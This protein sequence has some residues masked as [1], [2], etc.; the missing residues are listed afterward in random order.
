MS[1]GMMLPDRV[2]LEKFL[3]GAIIFG[4]AKERMLDVMQVIPKEREY[5]FTNN[6]NRCI[7]RILCQLSNLDKLPNDATLIT[8][9]IWGTIASHR[10]NYNC[11]M[12]SLDEFSRYIY[13]MS[14]DKLD[15]MMMDAYLDY[16]NIVKWEYDKNEY[17]KIGTAIANKARNVPF[18][19]RDN[20]VSQAE[21][22]INNLSLAVRNSTGLCD[23]KETGSS[24]LSKIK[25]MMNWEPMESGLKT[26]F[27]GLDQLTGGF[28][29]GE[30]IIV[31]GKTGAGKSVLSSNIALNVACNRDNPR[32]VLL[33]SMEMMP[34]QLTERI[35]AGLSRVNIKQMNVEYERVTNGFY[36]NTYG[37]TLGKKIESDMKQK[38][39]VQLE[40]LEIASK[41]NDN[42][43]IFTTTTGNLNAN[44]I[45]SLVL[46]KTREIENDSR[47]PK[48]GLIV[49][50]YLQIMEPVEKG[51]ANRTE[52]VGDMSR[53]LKR[54]AKETGIPVLCLAQLSRANLDGEQ[55]TLAHLRESGSI[56]QDADKVVFIWSPA[57]GK[58]E[59]DYEVPDTEDSDVAKRLLMYKDQ[60]HLKLTVA[61]NRS[62][63]Q[64]TVDIIGD[65]SFQTFISQSDAYKNGGET[66]ESF[67]EKYYYKTRSGEDI[68]WPLPKDNLP[69]PEMQPYRTLD[70][71]E[72]LYVNHEN[73]IVK[74]SNL[75]PTTKP[76]LKQVSITPTSMNAETI[77][78]EA[79][80]PPPT[81]IEPPT[82]QTPQ[83]Q[84]TN[85]NLDTPNQNT[86]DEDLDY[87]SI[88]FEPT[89]NNDKI[90]NDQNNEAT[91]NLEN[92]LSQLNNL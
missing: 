77:T 37:E 75:I 84:S 72:M 10:K 82:Y 89:N 59:A 30:L 87:M 9:E 29:P 43:P 26:G 79:I 32:S 36:R 58:T 41:Y 50:D 34:E 22:K 62:G 63:E 56:E 81:K 53:R 28:N 16:A 39:L 19:E 8:K 65:F 46:Q 90:I 61:K 78:N 68:F 80:I 67:F 21:S 64:G 52:E 45:K 47:Y 38:I 14:V 17:V 83:T 15:G 25:K 7:Y 85:N 51:A 11:S 12:N 49:I 18:S 35:L 91:E 74:P 92:L 23:S 24:T 44:Q 40:R 6:D 57:R 13:S 55:P 2:L 60:M 66:F 73:K 4:N 88:D 69:I 27:T 71:P 48:V 5:Y 31:A 1:D 33:F 54:L 86:E 20:F 3:L 42:L 70:K 76:T